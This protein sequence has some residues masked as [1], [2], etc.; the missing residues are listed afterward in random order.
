MIDGRRAVAERGRVKRRLL[1]VP[2]AV[3]LLF[4]ADVAE[5]APC[6]CDHVIELDGLVVNGTDL[7]VQPGQSVCVRGGAREYLRLQEFVGA[8][9]S[10]IEIRNCEGQVAIDNEDRGY[11][12]TVD[13]SRHVR[14][15]G[16]GDAE[17]MYGFKVRAART[18]PDYAAMGV[19][20]GDL[21]SDI[22]ADHMEVY[23]SG[24]AGFMMK[25]DPRCDGSS[26]LG[27]FVMYNSKLHHN[28]IHDTHG[29]GIYFG[30][31]GYGGRTYT[32]DGMEVTL[33]PHEHHGAEIHDNIIENT[34]WDGAQIGVTP[35]GC[36]FYRNVIK[37]VGLAGEMYQQQGLQ[38]GGASVCE[39]WGNVLMDGPTNGLFIFGTD[40]T[41]IYNNLIVGFGN[42]GIYIND[43]GQDLAA[44]M[45]VAH[46]TVID[47]GE[48][49]IV[50]FGG[51]LGPGSIRNNAVAGAGTA[52]IGVGMEVMDIVEEGN[53]T[54]DDPGTFG[55]VDLAGRD[56]H[57]TPTS[58]LRDAGVAVP[59]LAIEDDLDGT[60]RD[61]GALDVGAY[62]YS[63]TPATT[64]ETSTSEG[65]PTTGGT[66]GSGDSESGGS[67]S[68]GGGSSGPTSS[69]GTG[70]PD[71]TG[72]SGTTGT[73][74]AT[75]GEPAEGEASGCACTSTPRP[76]SAWPAL[77]MLVGLRRRRRAMR[78]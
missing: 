21:S 30:S 6:D 39:I 52:P 12:L 65:D 28:Y 67:G 27:N 68:S 2:V 63:E 18:G 38:V 19:A 78:V 60:P 29:E 71:S 47:S 43:Q 50:A 23:D 56:F 33:Y 58:A 76:G 5:A 77:L 10:P 1:V 7:G 32:C 55:F 13:R 44:E 59:D 37:N 61:D 9:G 3:S 31:T 54:S 66:G 4:V 26:N 17:F 74:A 22:E 8:E 64:G 69:A 53:Q 70:G 41:H 20:I 25:T 45:R 62:E 57:L 42:S 36:A 75:A 15:T 48:W 11:G 14:V 46:N 35:V 24:F 16:T 34:G 40:D 49:G 73:D 72:E 51:L